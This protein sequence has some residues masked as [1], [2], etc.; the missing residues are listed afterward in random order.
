L[1][2][3]H[4]YKNA[5]TSVDRLLEQSFGKNWMNWDSAAP[6]KSLRSTDIHEVVRQNPGIMALSS[7]SSRL[8]W[9]NL[10]P[11]ALPIVFLRHPIDRALS[12]YKFAGR[13]ST[14]PDHVHARGTFRDYVEWALTSSDGGIVIRNY[15]VTHL[16]EAPLRVSHVWHAEPS[17][18]DLRHALDLLAEWPAFGIVRQ[19][20]RS[21]ARFQR[22]YAHA[23]PGLLL[24]DVHL[25]ASPYPFRTER[26][27]IEAG[28]EMLGPGLF[29]D[30]CGVNEL[31]L[32]LYKEAVQRF[33]QDHVDEKQ[34]E[35]SV[36]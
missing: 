8:V 5:G 20:Q 32:D 11:E 30:L 35:P 17:G 25:N 9:P 21:M 23:F 22:A 26:A 14:Q 31:D 4:I 36:A 2:H 34:H 7:H 10:I 27:A 6:Q 19:F 33:E 16:S 29:D 3:A 15:Q 1:V 12:V 28:L 18:A 13:D 24:S